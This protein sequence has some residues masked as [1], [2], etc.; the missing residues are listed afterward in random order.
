MRSVRLQRCAETPCRRALVEPEVV[1][2]SPPTDG[3]LIE[4]RARYAE[5]RLVVFRV[6][7][8]AGS[9]IVG[10][11]SQRVRFFGVIRQRVIGYAGIRVT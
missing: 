11:I 10:R 2:E 4:A 1:A 6:A 9:G 8:N 7:G 5:L 3:G